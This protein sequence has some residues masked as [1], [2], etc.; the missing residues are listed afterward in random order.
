MAKP[1]S[2]LP[3]AQRL[4]FIAISLGI[5]LSAWGALYPSNTWLQVGPVALA[6]PF[7]FLALR[8]WPVSNATALCVTLF[9]VLH[10]IAARW[11]YSYVP[12]REWLGWLGIGTV[13][14]DAHRNMF[15]RLVHFSFGLL[16]IIPFCEIAQRHG[17]LTPRQALFGAI[18]FV[19]AIGGLYEIFEWLLTITL[20]P[21]DAGAYNGEQ[22]DR[23][24]SQK[25]MAMAAV[26]ALI[27][28]PLQLR[29]TRRG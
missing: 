20:S 8:K 18:L 2:I 9:V 21:A 11:S 14:T 17:G 19:L 27:A 1:D 7:A 16:A 28:V 26:G 13:D 6:L 25:D 23:F 3:P 15:D 22:G 29:L 12:Y 4:M 5:P 10:L 24:D